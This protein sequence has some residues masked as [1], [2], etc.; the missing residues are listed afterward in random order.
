MVQSHYG[1]LLVFVR[2]RVEIRGYVDLMTTFGQ[3]KLSWSFTVRNLIVDANT[4]YFTLT[5]RK[6]LNEL[7]AIVSTPHLKMKFPTF[8][9][10]IVTVK[11]D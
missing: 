2:E 3:G 4:S 5:H 7:G 6:P 8:T 10:E 11:V 9:G 1:P